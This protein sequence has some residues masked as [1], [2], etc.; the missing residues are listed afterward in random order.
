MAGSA[1][2]WLPLQ[3]SLLPFPP[4]VSW[5]PGLLFLATALFLV[6]VWDPLFC[7]KP[8]IISPSLNDLLSSETL[9]ATPDLSIAG[10]FAFNS[11][12][13]LLPIPSQ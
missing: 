13:M 9:T 11:Y 12:A 10:G 1:S 7:R 5:S 2:E 6:V 4:H 8:F 3:N